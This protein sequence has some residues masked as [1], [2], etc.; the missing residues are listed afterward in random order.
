[1]RKKYFQNARKGEKGQSLVE[2]ALV[3]PLLLLLLIGIAEFGRAWMTKNI[4]TG[5][6]REAVRMAA[7][8]PPTGMDNNTW[9]LAINAR[10]VNIL[11]SAGI[12]ADNIDIVV[13]VGEYGPVSVTVSYNF[14]LVIPGFIPGLDNS[15]I[16][17]SSATTMRREY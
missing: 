4:L 1:M 15:T 11:Q 10:A 16:P 14:P 2:F 6:A 8:S 13:D 12:V 3:V 9:N 5:A 7:V 17:L